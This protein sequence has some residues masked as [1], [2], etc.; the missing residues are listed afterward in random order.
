MSRVVN[1]SLGFRARIAQGVGR[2]CCKARIE[3]KQSDLCIV[4]CALSG[5]SFGIW[6]FDSCYQVRLIE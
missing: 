3:L 2:I 4:V 1:V 5:I 6:R